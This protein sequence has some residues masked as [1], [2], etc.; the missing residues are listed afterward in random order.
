MS[1]E[2][3]KT[4]FDRIIP[5]R[6]GDVGF[7]YNAKPKGLRKKRKHVRKLQRASRRINRKG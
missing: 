7:H 5:Y 1:R 3:L 6:R 2:I 4:K